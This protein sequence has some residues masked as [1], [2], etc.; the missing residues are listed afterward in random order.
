MDARLIKANIALFN[1]AREECRRFLEEYLDDGLAPDDK[2]APMV[3]WLD[4][5]TLPDRK[6]R[7]LRLHELVATYGY[8]N[9]YGRMALNTLRE[10]EKF[11][12]EMEAARP[13]WGHVFGIALWKIALFVL[14]AGIVSVAAWYFTGN[15]QSAQETALARPPDAAQPTP[16]PALPDR[17][18]A[19][20][21]ANYAAQYR[22]GNL[23][24]VAL[25]DNS[26]RVVTLGQGTLVTP[27]P[28][29][30]FYAL[31]LLFECRAGI[32]R[33]PPEGDFAL[34]LKDGIVIPPRTEVGIAGDTL[35][36]PIAQGR[37]TSGWVVFE[38]PVA[39]A[40]VEFQIVPAGSAEDTP[41]LLI[42][43]PSP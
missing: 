21:G 12:D 32:C 19:I 25:E 30:R 8:E 4:A 7:L 27:V 38:I 18:R 1:G 6:A 9:P 36:Q 20:D 22:Q 31:K 39:S 16:A 29:A 37:T 28:G 41:P 24:I 23:Q 2:H 17:S 43:L 26:A 5:Q 11:A 40:V 42:V 34:R 13:R 10:E 15:N 33:N 35:L 3:V 14:I